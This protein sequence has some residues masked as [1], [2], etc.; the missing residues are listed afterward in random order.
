MER[1]GLHGCVGIGCRGLTQ[2]DTCGDEV[3]QLLAACAV[4]KQVASLQVAVVM[5]VLWWGAGTLAHSTCPSSVL[6]CFQHLDITLGEDHSSL[7]WQSAGLPMA[8]DQ[9]EWVI[10]CRRVTAGCPG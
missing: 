10:S 5:G 4:L 8:G 2:Q 1:A 6:S 9:R 3:S 7:K